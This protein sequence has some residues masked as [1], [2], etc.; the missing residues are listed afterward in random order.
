MNEDDRRAGSNIRIDDG[1]LIDTDR[2]IRNAMN[3]FNEGRK[4]YWSGTS[5][6][7]QTT[8]DEGKNQ[9]EATHDENGLGINVD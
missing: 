8:N 4:S 2:V 1:M 6:K 9:Q 3:E 7:H 5:A